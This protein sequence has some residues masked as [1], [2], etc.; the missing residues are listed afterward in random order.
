MRQLLSIAR[1][2]PLLTAAILIL[3]VKSIEFAV[4][5][6]ALFYF[7]SGAFIVN[8]MRL[9]FLPHRSYVNGFLIRGF[10]VPFHSLRAIVAM[11]ASMGGIT[12][13]LLSFALL[14]FFQV[15]DWIAILAGLAFAMD[16]VQVVYDHLVMTENAAMLAIALFWW[17]PSSICAI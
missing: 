4:D 10:A 12:A 11:Q 2:A 3:L 13:W 8:A 7:D 9:G 14:R 15:R 16:P 1:R 6:Q 17:R 5:S